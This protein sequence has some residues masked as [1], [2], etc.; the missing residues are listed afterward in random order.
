MLIGDSG[1][2]SAGAKNINSKKKF[3]T[4]RSVSSGFGSKERHDNGHKVAVVA[5][6]TRPCCLC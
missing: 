6:S 1:K 5:T 4:V 3:K 2:Y